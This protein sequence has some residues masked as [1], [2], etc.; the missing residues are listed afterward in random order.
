MM[1][2]QTGTFSRCHQ[3]LDSIGKI[4]QQSVKE[5]PKDVRKFLSEVSPARLKELAKMNCFAADKIKTE[6]DKKYGKGKYVIISLGR[7]LS[8]ICEL[9]KQ[10]GVDV[11]HLP[12]SD[13]RRNDFSHVQEYSI[14]KF[15]KFLETAGLTKEK[16][17]KNSDKKYILMDYTYYGR[18]LDKTYEFLKRSDMLGDS[19][20]FIKLPVCKV[21]GEDYIKK[22]YEKLFQFSRF[23]YFA[24][25]GKVSI[26]RLS[27]IF[28]Q[29][30]PDTAREYRGN[31]TKGLRELF[32]FN[33]FDLMK[34]G[35]YK[36]VFPQKEIDALYNHYLSPKAVQNFIKSERK[37]QEQI[38]E[39]LIKNK[40]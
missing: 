21:L 15:K 1:N 19:H 34:S 40:K 17:K 2:I 23:K 10:L 30:N 26:Q 5:L 3:Y 38:V 28:M 36:N 9:I 13:L 25:V 32:W 22:G 37:K 8:S 24:M 39:S 20:N 27:N 7:S 12:L 31:T 16:L 33:V 18:S 14:I 29:S 11:I 35:E 4:N 6:L